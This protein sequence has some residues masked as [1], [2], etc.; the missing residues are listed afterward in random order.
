MEASPGRQPDNEE[1]QKAFQTQ[2]QKAKSKSNTK[3]IQDS[4]KGKTRYAMSDKKY[5]VD[6]RYSILTHT[7]MYN[8]SLNTSL[9]NSYEN[10]K[11]C[12]PC[13]VEGI[14][15]CLYFSYSLHNS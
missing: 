7:T 8:Y 6:P 10:G 12:Q 2:I 3:G 15:P 4:A 11:T 1:I 9:T 5:N 13:G 14:L